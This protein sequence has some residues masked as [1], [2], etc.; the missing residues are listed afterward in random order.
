MSI[1]LSGTQMTQL[2]DA[3][4]ILLSPLESTDI[5]DY[6]SRVASAL[7]SLIGGDRSLVVLPQE[8]PDQNSMYADGFSPTEVEAY[9][10]AFPLDHGTRLVHSLGWE[11]WSHSMILQRDAKTFYGTPI[12]HE[13]YKPMGLEDGIG[14]V[15]RLPEAN[16]FALVKVHH[17]TYGTDGFGDR[18]VALLSLLLPA[19][20]AGAQ[21]SFRVVRQHGQ[22]GDV[23]DALD[24]GFRVLDARC[25]T[26]HDNAALSDILITDPERALLEDAMITTARAAISALNGDDV[27][28]LSARGGTAR[29]VRTVQGVYHVRAN[30]LPE[31]LLVPRSCV[32]VII[33]QLTRRLPSAEDLSNRFRLTRQEARVAYMLA[34]GARNDAIATALRISCHTSRRHT[35]R[36]F[37]KMGVHSRSAV[38]SVLEAEVAAAKHPVG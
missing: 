28:L 11:V 13:Y 1:T 30:L 26:L 8:P 35:E 37:E 36:V 27:R 23:L 7:R 12:Y 24:Q 3:A 32:L 4:R 29:E 25:R 15:I 20:K 10:R 18:G 9:R 21:A 19:F 5:C 14:Y 34:N 22:I 16:S 17:S 33:E 6:A 2:S 38:R 31:N